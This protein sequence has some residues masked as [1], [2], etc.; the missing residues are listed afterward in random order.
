MASFLDTVLFLL[1]NG[2]FFRMVRKPSRAWLAQ[3]FTWSTA[4]GGFWLYGVASGHITSTRDQVFWG[5]L[6]TLALSSF[7][8]VLLGYTR[9]YLDAPLAERPNRIRRHP[10]AL[11]VTWRAL[12]LLK[13]CL[14]LA[15]MALAIIA[16]I[17][18]LVG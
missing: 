13:L 11:R 17:L 18:L 4:V 9:R 1:S 6:T 7:I 14:V 12:T 8:E 3:S 15:F 10:A 2:S 5:F 16:L